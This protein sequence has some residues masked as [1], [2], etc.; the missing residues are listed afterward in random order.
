MA[1]VRFTSIRSIGFYRTTIYS[2]LFISKMTVSWLLVALYVMLILLAYIL[3]ATWKNS[4]FITRYDH[5]SLSFI[6]LI[7][8][9]AW[10]VS[11]KLMAYEYRKGLSEGFYS[12]QLFWMLNTLISFAIFFVSFTDLVNTH[13]SIFPHYFN[14]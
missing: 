2:K 10:I 3:P 4:E 5:R 13:D 7:N 11:I 1:F 14:F 12:H 9:A 6:Y 8:I